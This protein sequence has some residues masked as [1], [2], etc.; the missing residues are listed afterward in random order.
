MPQFHHILFV[1]HGLAE[2]TAALAQALSLARNHSATLRALVVCPAFPEEMAQYRETYEAALR[3]QLQA[4]LQATRKTVRVSETQVPVAIAVESGDTP[5]IRIIRQVLRHA[6]D[7]VVKAADPGEEGRG[8]RAMDMELLRKCPCAL[9]LTRPID[10]HREAIRVAVA[11]DPQSMA[12]EGHDLSLRLLA[13]SRALAD[14]CSGELQVV[15]CWDYEFEE[16]LRHNLWIKISND[17]LIRTV[18]T[19]QSKHRADLEE[20]VRQSGIQGRMQLHHVRGRA[21]RMIPQYMKDL[22]IDIL[23]M[24]TVARTGIPGFLIGNTAENI[25]QKL[26]CSLLALKP[27]GFVSPVKAYQGN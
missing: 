1:S 14:T 20:L 22:D 11:V 3:E 27:N 19:T 23:V 2:E 24:G 17:E 21:D 10:R 12:P 6:H 25:V 4:S 8:F 9:W 18:H 26:G 5:A 13:L 7:L 15:S 16:Y